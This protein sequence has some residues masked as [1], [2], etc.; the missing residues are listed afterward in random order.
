MVDKFHLMLN[1]VATLF[2]AFLIVVT[3]NGFSNALIA[4]LMGDSTAE[5]EGFLT[6]NP[7]AHV[8]CFGVIGV[9]FLIGFLN[10][11]FGDG[12]NYSFIMAVLILAGIQWMYRVPINEN[13]FRNRKLGVIL[14]VLSGTIGLSVL[15]ILIMYMLRYFPFISFS[16]AFYVPLINIL[17][18]TMNLASWFIVWDLIPIPPFDGAKLLPHIIPLKYHFI[19]DWL[20]EN[21]LFIY[22]FL[23]LMPFVS[24]IFFGL[25][26]RFSEL[27]KVAL[28]FFVF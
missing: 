13:N 27:I 20:E 15:I 8:D 21:S 26:H 2:P 23:I 25:L 7:L 9:L 11:I 1:Y 5:E 18:A 4:K 6:L 16:K 14:S 19:I 10:F 3:I 12:F 17:I 28:S 22:I 24:E